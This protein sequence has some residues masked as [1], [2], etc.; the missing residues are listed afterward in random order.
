MHIANVKLSHCEAKF[1]RVW[2][3]FGRVRRR[4]ALLQTGGFIVVRFCGVL[5]CPPD[6]GGSRGVAT[7]IPNRT[8]YYAETL[9]P[10]KPSSVPSRSQ[11]LPLPKT[12]HTHNSRAI[13]F[14][15]FSDIFADGSRAQLA[16]TGECFTQQI[17]IMGQLNDSAHNRL[18][19]INIMVYH[20]A[21]RISKGEKK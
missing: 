13:Q 19:H 12:L 11:T 7:C 16:P 2:A 14:S 21:T 5:T 18:A 10:P 1:C 8:G 9:K 17:K 4:I 6:K 20:I 3:K 15:I